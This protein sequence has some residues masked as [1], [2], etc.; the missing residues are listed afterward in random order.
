MAYNKTDWI[1]NSLPPIDEINLNKIEDGIADAQTGVASHAAD[2]NNPHSVTQTQVGLKD[3]DNTS[4]IDKPVST[5]TQTALDLKSD[6]T[7]T[8]DGVDGYKVDHINLNSIG[9]NTHSEI[10]IHITEA[11]VDGDALTLVNETNKLLTEHE[12]TILN[13][14]IDNL[15]T[16][17]I[18]EAGNLYYTDVRADDRV[19][20]A[21]KDDIISLS[22]L[23]SSFK[24][25]NL[26]EGALVY[27]GMWDA[28]LNIPTVVDGVGINGFFY[29]V[30]VA[31][32]QNLG[33]GAIDFIVGDRVIYNGTTWEK[34]QSSDSAN[35]G[36]I[37]GIIQDQTDLQDEFLLK[38]D[39]VGIDI[40]TFGGGT[41]YV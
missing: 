36:E 4:D 26:I 14:T 41:L 15:D 12:E 22:S 37:Y 38:A 35:W 28:D 27:Q 30:D 29:I 39:K 9:T 31:G 2:T 23:Y 25:E 19:Q 32:T 8:H 34:V 17:D 21:I 33:S 5:A 13:G 3:V 7:H 16:D 40:G 20:E 6:N 24:I 11:L 10:D 1:D 18:A